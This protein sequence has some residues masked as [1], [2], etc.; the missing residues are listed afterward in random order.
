MG[1]RDCAGGAG[2][3]FPWDV[4]D[5]QWTDLKEVRG[6]ATVGEKKSG[7]EKF[8]GINGI[9]T[10][11]KATKTY[12]IIYWKIDKEGTQNQNPD[13]S[14]VQNEEDSA[15]ETEEICPDVRNNLALSTET[16][17][18]RQV[19]VV[20]SEGSLSQAQTVRAWSVH[21]LKTD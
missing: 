20:H 21:N 13:D 10:V 16:S 18:T 6:D 8:M 17:V 11:F 9:Q 5:I 3:E 15:K 1:E 2:L 12:S 19:Q 14:N 7:L 4:C